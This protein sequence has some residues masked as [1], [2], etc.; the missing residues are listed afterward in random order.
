MVRNSGH[1]QPFVSEFPIFCTFPPSHMPSDQI[2]ALFL[3]RRPT[4]VDGPYAILSLA[5]GND[6]N[7]VS[8]PS[9]RQDCA[10]NRQEFNLP[11]S[12]HLSAPILNDLITHPAVT[13]R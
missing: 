3:R 9:S 6:A 4:C 11:A 10:T 2:V 7:R 1:K 12:Q 8:P 5:F 13:R